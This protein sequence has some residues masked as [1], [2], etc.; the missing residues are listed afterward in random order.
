[1]IYVYSLLI[2]SHVLVQMVLDYIYFLVF[3][4]Q[5]HST[6]GRTKDEICKLKKPCM[7]GGYELFGLL[8]APR[9]RERK[10]TSKW[11][12]SQTS[13]ERLRVSLE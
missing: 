5:R 2:H 10:F 9:K 4:S 8:N 13:V 6:V 12:H 11:L 1:M 3:L 7:W